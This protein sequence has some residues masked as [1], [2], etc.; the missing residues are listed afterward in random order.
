MR[1]NSRLEKTLQRRDLMESICFGMVAIVTFAFSDM[2]LT[3]PPFNLPYGER[4]LYAGVITLIALAI[5]LF[6]MWFF[7]WRKKKRIEGAD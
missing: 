6:L 7:V 5:T 1:S 2:L 4:K 3:Y